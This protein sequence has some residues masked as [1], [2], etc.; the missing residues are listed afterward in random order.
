MRRRSEGENDPCHV[1]VFMFMG[2]LAGGMAG[3]E[4]L[5]WWWAVRPE[6]KCRRKVPEV[7]KDG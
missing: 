7:G 3:A 6:Q 4:D 1:Y 2:R 5:W